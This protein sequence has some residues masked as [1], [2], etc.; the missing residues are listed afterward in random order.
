MCSEK[1]YSFSVY[2]KYYLTITLILHIQVAQYSWFFPC[3]VI[4]V[5]VFFMC[6]N[7]SV[8][9]FRVWFFRVTMVTCDLNEATSSYHFGLAG[10][11]IKF[12]HNILVRPVLPIELYCLVINM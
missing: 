10:C 3:V 2:A 5:C 11:E 1:H 7:M 12:T 4:S 9:F 8:R 6:G